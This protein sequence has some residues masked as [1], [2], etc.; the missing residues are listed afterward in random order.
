MK[1]AGICFTKKGI[2]LQ[3]RLY[4]ELSRLGH[5]YKP[6]TISKYPKES[7]SVALFSGSLQEWTKEQFS[8]A[9]GILFI[10]ACGIAVRSI[11]PFLK[12]KTTDPAVLVLDECGEF[13][14]SLLSGHLGGAN[15]LAEQIA[16]RLNAVPVITTATDRNSAFAVDMFAKK[17]QCFIT[18]MK[19]AKDISAAVLN[20]EKIV[21]QS[22]FEVYG[23]LPKELSDRRTGASFLYGISMSFDKSKKIAEHT[24]ILIP[25]IVSLGIGCRKGTEAPEIERQVKMV[26]KENG[27][28]IEAVANAGSI[29]LKKEEQ[30]ILEFCAKFN[31]PFICYS[32]EELNQ[33]PGEFTDSEFVRSVT[34]VSNVCERAAVLASQNGKIIRRKHASEGITVALAIK[35]WRVCFV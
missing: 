19:L 23:N 2:L 10:G 26:L 33:A 8:S 15:E 5:T 22:D 7:S 18:S 3:E 14:I 24:L 21:F 29:D 9:E 4:G 34:G 27:I 16:E 30:G 35:E 31:I 11:A 6:Y 32:A 13:V 28:P 12:D 17:N 25:E 1:L 20:R